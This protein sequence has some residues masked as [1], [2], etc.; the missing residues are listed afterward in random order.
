MAY[1]GGHIENCLGLANCPHQAGDVD[2]THTHTHTRFHRWGEG[3]PPQGLDLP[4]PPETHPDVWDN[5]R[6]PGTL[7]G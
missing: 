2:D 7:T 3:K 4:Q 1:L 6:L 5:G